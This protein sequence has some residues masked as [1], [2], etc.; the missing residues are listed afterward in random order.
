MAADKARTACD[1]Y[2]THIVNAFS[3]SVKIIVLFELYSHYLSSF[4]AQTGRDQRHL[5]GWLKAVASATS[6]IQTQMAERLR[7][8]WND[9]KNKQKDS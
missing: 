5:A 3:S 7:R 6:G 1:Q 9:E 4:A 8:D 2:P